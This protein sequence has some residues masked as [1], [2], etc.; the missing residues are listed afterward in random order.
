MVSLHPRLMVPAYSC[1]YQMVLS[2]TRTCPPTTLIICLLGNGT[3]P[4]I[5]KAVGTIVLPPLWSVMPQVANL[6][7]H[8]TLPKTI[9]GM[10]GP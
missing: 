3:K 8:T 4:R 5:T 10:N 6:K 2:W 9:V 1:I 7:R